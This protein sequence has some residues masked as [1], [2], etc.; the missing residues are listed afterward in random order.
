MFPTFGPLAQSGTMFY[1]GVMAHKTHKSVEDARRKAM[2]GKE[3]KKKPA[4]TSPKNTGKSTGKDFGEDSVDVL[5]PWGAKQPPPT[6]SWQ[7]DILG[8]GFQSRS[9]RLQPD[10]EGE[11]VATLVRYSPSTRRR[12]FKWTSPRFV[13]LYL[14][15]RND[16]F[17]QGE[18]AVR[19]ADM[20]GAFYALDLRKYGRS[21]RPWQT[22]GYIEDLATYD[23]EIDLA[24][25]IIRQEHPDIPLVVVG[26]STGGLIGTLWTWRH[27]DQVAGLVLNSAWL[28]LQSLTALRPALRQLLGT[29]AYYQ[30]RATVI[31][32]SKFDTYNRSLTEG[33]AGS[34]FDL[35]PELVGEEDDPAVT[36]WKIAPE[37]KRPFSYPAPAAWC[38]AVLV[39]HGKIAKDVELRIP[40]LALASTGSQGE[41]VLDE[42]S[43]RSDIVLDSDLITQRAA[44]LSDRVTI[45]RLP[46][47]HDLTLSDPH[48]RNQF[49]SAVS[50]WVACNITGA[51]RG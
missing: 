42:R 35:P 9:I 1:G 38:T 51:G 25:D 20:G 40:V 30:P 46:G 47:K 23:E 8:E 16:Y 2:P 39:A 3:T 48:V 24:V 13:A 45:V 15:G 37:W 28:E 10:E 31:N 50:D 32:T 43:F 21:L 7:E 19:F 6:H 18:Q 5:R 14:H 34:G 11:V 26:H 4:K 41:E 49:Y 44:M 33:W 36:G 22:I 12:G 29:L 27:Q 17:H